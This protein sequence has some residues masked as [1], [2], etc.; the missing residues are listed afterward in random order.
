MKK[1]DDPALYEE[2]QGI[3][4]EMSLKVFYLTN[5]RLIPIQPVTSDTL[6]IFLTLWQVEECA[7]P[8]VDVKGEL[9]GFSSGFQKP[10]PSNSPIK[11]LGVFGRGARGVP[12]MVKPGAVKRKME[13]ADGESTEKKQKL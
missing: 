8:K 13:E 1:E 2:I 7:Q 4:E 11:D 5:D 9:D 10:L 3:K 6:D 12:R